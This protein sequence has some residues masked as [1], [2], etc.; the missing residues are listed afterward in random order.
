MFHFSMSTTLRLVFDETFFDRE[1][2]LLK[3]I[4]QIDVK[5]TIRVM[6]TRAQIKNRNDSKTSN[7]Q[8][9]KKKNIQQLSLSHFSRTRTTILFAI[10]ANCI[11]LLFDFVSV[12]TLLEFV[13]K[14]HMFMFIYD[15]VFL[16]LF[17]FDINF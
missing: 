11:Y 17:V 8:S 7:Q 2:N 14:K 6:T 13:E 5:T 15:L 10:S 12:I 9:T 1:R 3:Q 4:I 16:L